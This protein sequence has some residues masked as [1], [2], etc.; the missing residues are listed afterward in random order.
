[1]RNRAPVRH[2]DYFW[3]VLWVFIGA[4][5]LQNI[6]GVWFRAAPFLYN[7]VALSVDNVSHGKVWTIFTYSLMHGGLQ[8]FFINGILFFVIGRWLSKELEPKRFLHLILG[9]IFLGGVTWLG[10]HALIG[11]Q[12]LY[13]QPVIGF[14]AAIAGLLVTACLIWPHGQISL[15][16]F[17]ILPVSFNPRTLLWVVVGIDAIGFLFIELAYLLGYQPIM[18]AAGIAFSAHLGGA[19]AGYIFYRVLQRPAPL[20]ESV[21][22]KVS[23]EPPKWTKKR[24]QASTGKF[25]VNLTNRKDLRKEVDRILD[26]INREGFQS[27]NDEEKK[28]LDDAGDLLKK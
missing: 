26:K 9:S 24:T 13:G 28:V 27:L 3:W 10:I 8:H 21:A 1:M 15:L 6:L 16:L 25:K 4:F 19:L 22:K 2:V 17:F 7:W 20:F 18:Q 5:L 14:S 12:Q 11:P 23:V